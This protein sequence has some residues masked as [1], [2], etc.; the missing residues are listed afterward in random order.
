MIKILISF[1]IV[2]FIVCVTVN[3]GAFFAEKIM[4]KKIIKNSEKMSKKEE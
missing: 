2:S 4:K 3:V 1:L